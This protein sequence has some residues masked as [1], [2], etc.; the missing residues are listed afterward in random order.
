MITNEKQYRSTRIIADRMRASLASADYSHLHPLFAAAQRSAIESQVA[1]LEGD[2]SEYDQIKSGQVSRFEAEGLGDLPGILIRARIARGMSQKD[3][4]DFLG[5]KEQQIQRY[6]ADKYRAA[7]LERLMEVASALGVEVRQTGEFVGADTPIDYSAFPITEM[8]KRGWFEDFAGT[9]AQARKS[10]GTLIPTFLR[11]SQTR[12]SQMAL[13]RRTVRAKG[14]VHEVAISAWEARVTYL[15]DRNPPPCPFDRAHI[16]GDWVKRLSNLSI[17]PMGPSKTSTVLRDVGIA[18]VIE[19]Q[20]PGTLLDGAALKTPNG[21]CTIALTLRHNRLDNFWFTL[22]HELG[23]IVLHVSTDKLASIFD[24]TE[25]PAT[26]EVEQEADIFAQEALLSNDHWH[27]CLSRFSRTEK[28]VLS[29]AARFGI[30]PSIIAGRI[31]RES[32]DYT[33]LN[34]LVGT[35]EPRKQFGLT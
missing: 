29:D 10:A 28:S 24:D 6:E 21:V 12:Q 18:L 23:H 17:D 9:P 13:H 26:S 20:L 31:R 15:A 4:A 34:N 7:S 19:P 11:H 30:H 14:Q 33:I 22:M 5:I 32:R 2:L 16:T 25:S 27:S 3:L 1:E 8:A 35:G